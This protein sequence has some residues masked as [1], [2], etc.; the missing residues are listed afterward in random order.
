MKK[1]IITLL[2]LVLLLT[3]SSCSIKNNTIVFD[4]ELI[5]NREFGYRE[6]NGNL[7]AYDKKD[8]FEKAKGINTIVLVVNSNFSH[9]YY[10]VRRTDNIQD[11][12]ENESYT[13]RYIDYSFNGKM[14]GYSQIT[15][16]KI[17]KDDNVSYFINYIYYLTQ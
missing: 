15:F 9:A 7:I 13:Y 1:I 2:S 17:T 10:F 5:E 6:S 3:I 11:G 12:E 4:G 14:I 16:S 8:L